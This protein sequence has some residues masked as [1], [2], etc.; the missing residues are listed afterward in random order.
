MS[1]AKLAD[2]I[3]NLANGDITVQVD[4]NTQS[5]Q[6]DQGQGGSQSPEEAAAVEKATADK[7]AKEKAAKDQNDAVKHNIALT[8]AIQDMEALKN[9]C[10]EYK[11]LARA[12][13][14][15][16]EQNKHSK[17]MIKRSIGY[18]IHMI[19]DL[20]LFKI[21]SYYFYFE[22]FTLICFCYLFLYIF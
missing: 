10:D 5:D 11:T 20:F 19:I 17:P 13:E 1:G 16:A 12:T 4:D 21:F 9:K 14:I 8:A 22:I 3:S 2:V 18:T 7:A 15:T 6:S